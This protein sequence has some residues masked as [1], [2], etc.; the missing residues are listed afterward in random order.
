[1]T[2]A[3]VV[4]DVPVTRTDRPF[5]Y[6]V[7]SSLQGFV[8]VGS[9]VMVPFGPRKLQGFVIELA[10]D[11]NY[12]LEKVRDIEEVLDLEAPLTPELIQL[13]KWMSERYMSTYYGALQVMIPSALRSKYEKRISLIE[14]P[15][16]FEILPPE[17]QECYDY[18][19]RFS[20]VSFDTFLKKF[21]FAGPWVKEGSKRVF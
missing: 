9:R 12:S 17:E 19:A 8:Q 6:R 4:V 21:P 15:G 20:P 3:R 18:L 2:I 1:M 10:N 13:A 11:A 16:E 14:K 7:P 5:D